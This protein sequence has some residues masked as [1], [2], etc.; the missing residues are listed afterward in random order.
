MEKQVKHFFHLLD[1][2]NKDDAVIF[3]LQ[4]LK[5]GKTI[6]DV[7]ENFII[8]S[9]RDYHCPSNKTEIC[10]WKE[11]TRTSIIRTIIESTYPILISEKKEPLLNKSII[12]ACPQEEYH[13]IGALISTHYLYLMGFKVKYI[14]ANT[15]SSDIESAINIM[16]PD[17]LALSISNDYNLIQ[18]K[19]L[20]ERLKANYP[21]LNIILGG[22]AAIAH[23]KSVNIPFDYL[24]ND[25]AD[26]RK[27]RGEFV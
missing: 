18:T 11:H 3:I 21:N 24:I 12:V 5:D 17:Y 2:E 14:G 22:R 20:V 6:F 26:I 8:P 19:K 1:E 16:N 23:A 27:F 7:Y 25:L 15:P 4:L 10:V 9:L 13:E